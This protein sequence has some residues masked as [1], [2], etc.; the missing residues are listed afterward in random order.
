M[1]KTS[2][3]RFVLMIVGASLAF[4]G[5]VCLVVACWD[6]LMNCGCAVKNAVTG[7]SKY[8]EFSDYEDELLYE[9]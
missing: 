4:A 6:K 3:W 9:D 1:K 5:A 8:S 7:K 2:T